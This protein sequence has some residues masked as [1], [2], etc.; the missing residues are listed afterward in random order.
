MYRTFY[1]TPVQ[2]IFVDPTDED[3]IIWKSGIAYLDEVICGCCGSVFDITDIISMEDICGHETLF[4]YDDW[5]NISDEI[6]GDELPAGLKMS[7]GVVIVESNNDDD[8]N[9]NNDTFF[10]SDRAN[11]WYEDDNDD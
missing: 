9:Y 6:K 7:N 2:V 10:E 11:I 5:I 3:S 8:D 4:E 1:N